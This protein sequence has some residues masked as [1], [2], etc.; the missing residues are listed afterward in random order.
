M[1]IKERVRDEKKSGLKLET[2][3]NENENQGQELG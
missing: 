1:R 2:S 3:L